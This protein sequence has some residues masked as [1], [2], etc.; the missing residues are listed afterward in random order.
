MKLGLY[1]PSQGY[2]VRVMTAVFAGVLFLWGAAWAWGE[3]ARV[4]LPVRAWEAQ[5]SGVQG[6]ISEGTRL[7]LLIRDEDGDRTVIGTASAAA[8]VQDV[9]GRRLLELVEPRMDEGRHPSQAQI[10]RAESNGSVFTARVDGSPR[11]IPVLEQEFLQGG[12]AGVIILFG[13]ILIYWFVGV[14]PRTVEFLIATDNEMKKVNWST[15]REVIGS[16]WVVVIASFVL[17]A[18]LFGV[19]NLFSRFFQFIGV[20]EDLPS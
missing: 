12:V 4:G 1:K 7:E 17:A 2:W 10:I 3:A 20:L 18:F 6:E 5:V 19:D 16:T 15:R 9:A 14:K 11:A 13:A 8:G